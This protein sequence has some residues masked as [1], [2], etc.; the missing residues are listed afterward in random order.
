MMN[1]ILMFMLLSLN[2]QTQARTYSS[3]Q[4]QLHLGSVY[5]NWGIIPKKNLQNLDP[6]INLV[7]AL[8]NFKEKSTVTVAVVDTGIDYK[9]EYFRKNIVSR[10]SERKTASKKHLKKYSIRM[11]TNKNFGFDFSSSHKG[12]KY[13]TKTPQDTHGHGTHV[14]GII[15]GIYPNV[16]IIPIKYYNANATGEQNLENSIRALEH[17]VNLNV[18]IINYSGG[19]PEAD[20]SN[21]AK[22]LRIMKKAQE[23]GILVVAAA[24]NNGTNIDMKNNMYFPASYAYPSGYNLQ[25]II[26]VGSY[27]QN[28]KLISS[29]NY[30]V[31]TVHVAAPGYRINSAVVK[32]AA[33]MS[34][35]S[36]ATAFVSGVAALLK[37]AY[38]KLTSRQI[39]EIIISTSKNLKNFQGKI[40]GGQ[41]DAAQ[42]LKKAKDIMEGLIP[43]QRKVART[44]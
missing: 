39:K 44:K 21:K 42:A 29:S 14:S 38:P 17:A 16:K 18:D 35:T 40:L 26:A 34:G 9:H 3:K 28:L 19:G 25:N 8:K 24:G 5:S 36:Q 13:V 33:K 6:S 37:S 27:N 12:K 1:F 20:P 7:N 41:V 2:L 15:K 4:I 32:K 30:G 11:A 10:F 31:R 22:E 43:K 23:K